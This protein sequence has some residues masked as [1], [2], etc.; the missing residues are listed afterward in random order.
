MVLKSN[1]IKR[2]T[3]GSLMIVLFGGLIFLDG[4]VSSS[5]GPIKLDENRGV[6]IAILVVGYWYVWKKGALEWD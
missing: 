4:W 3:F 5:G 6:F 1:L 2:I